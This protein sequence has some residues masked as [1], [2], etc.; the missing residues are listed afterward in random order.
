MSTTGTRKRVPIETLKYLRPNSLAPFFHLVSDYKG[1]GKSNYKAGSGMIRKTSHNSRLLEW[2][3]QNAPAIAFVPTADGGT[4]GATALTVAAADAPHMIPKRTLFNTRTGAMAEIY[5]VN[6]GTGVVSATTIGDIVF[7][8]DIA[9]KSIILCST[10]YEDGSTAPEYVSQDE[11]YA[12][13]VMQE[14][15]EPWQVGNIAAKEPSY[16]GDTFNNK[17]DQAVYRAMC[18]LENSVQFGK[19]ASSGETTTVNSASVPTMMGMWNWAAAGLDFPNAG[20]LTH[21]LF[22]GDVYPALPNTMN[23]SDEWVL[24]CGRLVDGA[25]QNMAQN[26]VSYCVDMSDSKA[27]V[28]YGKY[29]QKFR[30]GSMVVKVVPCTQYD[31]PGMTDKALLVSPDDVELVNYNGMDLGVDTNIQANDAHY[32]KDELTGVMTI[33]VKSAGYNMARFSGITF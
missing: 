16:V 13:N 15:R 4:S 3:F 14:I 26:D 25:I 11:D 22:T 10:A 29:F 18:L 28:P 9:D 7:T 12:Y 6:T 32:R 21:E 2:Y 19:R 20:A 31:Q 30:I 27:T 23:T 8:S 5:A 33:K 24:F 1:D 17:Q